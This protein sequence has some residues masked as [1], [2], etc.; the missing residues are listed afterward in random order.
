MKKLTTIREIVDALGGPSQ[1][2]KWAG[3]NDT[4]I[5][6]WIDRSVIPP[7]WHMRLLVETRKRGLVIDMTALGFDAKLAGEVEAIL[8]RQRPKPRPQEAA[9]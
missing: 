1:V 8:Y 7:A 9:A 4:A 3:V 6:N 2:A 5:H